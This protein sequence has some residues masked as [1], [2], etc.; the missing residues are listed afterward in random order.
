M[1]QHAAVDDLVKLLTKANYDLT[2]VQHRLDKE[3]QQI[4]PH[5]ANPLKL[6]SRIKK[7]QEDLSSLKE[8]CRELL[9]AKQMEG[10]QSTIGK[11]VKEAEH[12][13]ESARWTLRDTNIYIDLMV[14]E[15]KKGTRRT[16]TFSKKGWKDIQ[17]GFYQKTGHEYTLLQ[18][19]NKFQKLRKEYREFKKLIEVTGFDWNPVTK[20]AMAE[21]SVW[22]T[23]IQENAYAA[24][25]RKKGCPR[26]VELQLIYGENAATGELVV[27]HAKDPSDSDEDYDPVADLPAHTDEVIGATTHTDDAGDSHLRRRDRTP[28]ALRRGSKSPE[29]TEACKPLNVSRARM[30]SLTGASSFTSPSSTVEVDPYSIANCMEVLNTLE[31]VGPDEFVKGMKLLQDRGW[32]E[33]FM[34]VPHEKKMWLLQRLP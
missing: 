20:T 27:R 24:T 17:A 22:N 5:N 9:A 33:A 7:I 10:N 12:E 31:G 18:F 34:T 32:R 23:Y 11:M 28:T 19:R 30:A 3:F 26:W 25:F 14:E 16:T 29:F 6:V 4:Y 13:I 2:L 15:V 21:D 1:A 8:E